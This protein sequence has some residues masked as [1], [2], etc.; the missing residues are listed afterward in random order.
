MSDD[1]SAFL[2]GEPEAETDATHIVATDALNAMFDAVEDGSL[3][4]AFSALG[5]LL[6][7]S[8]SSFG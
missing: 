8:G 2:P 4:D 7:G 3:F 1:A 6:G 5:F